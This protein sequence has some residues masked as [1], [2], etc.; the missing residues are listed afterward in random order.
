MQ[1]ASDIFLGWHRIIAVDGVNRDYYMRQ[2]WD[3]KGSAIIDT[4]EPGVLRIYG[5]NC[6]WTLA[7][8]HTRSGDPIAIG[9]YVGSG[10][11]CD[12]AINDFANSYADQNEVDHQVLIESIKAG[13]LAAEV[14]G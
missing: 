13:R 3:W 8:A 12:D 11:A 14:G 2:L 6:G 5:G 10:A 4:M 1:A 7:R 9:A